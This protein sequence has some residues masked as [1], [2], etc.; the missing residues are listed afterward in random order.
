VQTLESRRL[1]AADSIGVT[2]D[3][4]GEYLVGTVLVTPVFFESNGE[5]DTETQNWTPDEI[6]EVLAKIS[7]GVNWWS[8]MLD[9]LD[10]VHTLEFTFDE[11]YA[12][13]PVS[14]PYEPIDNS[15]SDLNLSIGRFLTDAG[16]GDAST[17]ED[18]VKAF[19]HDQRIKPEYQ[20]DW[21]FTIFVADSSD[22]PDGLFASGGDF[23]A[24]FAYPGG[25]FMVSPSTRPASTFAH[26]MGHIFWA[27]D[28]YSNAGS[29]TDTRG[30]YNAQNLNAADNPT[31]GFVQQ[32]SIMRGGIP[33]GRAYDD[34]Q[35]PASTLA[36]VGWQDSDGDG[37]FDFA[38]VPLRLEGVGSFDPITSVYQFSGQ[39][40]VV[41]LRNLNSSGTQSDIALGQISRLEYRLDGAGWQTAAQIGA[42]RSN[43]QTSFQIE[44]EFDIIELRVI[45]DATGVTSPTITG[46]ANVAAV[47]QGG[48]IG[49]AFLDINGDGHRDADESLLAGNTVQVRHA[50]G[51]D[52]FASS[53]SAGE[54]DEGD[55][56]A[57]AA[58]GINLAASG[59][60]SQNGLAVYELSGQTK[61]VFQSFNLQSQRWTPRFD[62]K[63]SLVANLDS[64]VAAVTVTVGGLDSGSYARME[65][66]DAQGNFLTRQT[67][68]LIASGQETT[69]TVNDP[70]GK[71]RSV[72][73][74]G[75]ADTSITVSQLA[76]GT[77]GIAQ[78]DAL[79][80]WQIDDL[81]SGDYTIEI[82]PT[83]VI[84]DYTSL[85]SLVSVV[86][87]VSPM[88]MA[89]AA[90]VDSPRHNAETPADVNRLDGITALDALQIINDL[91][92]LG[93]RTLTANESE[94]FAI[95]VNNDGMATALDA[96]LVINRLAE[97]QNSGENETIAPLAVDTAF[98]T[99]PASSAATQASNLGFDDE[100]PP[101]FNL[102][103]HDIA[104][105]SIGSANAD[106]AR[107][108][109][110]AVSNELPEQ[111]LLR[112]SL[113]GH[114]LAAKNP[115]EFAEPF[116]NGLV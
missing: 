6:S 93:S 79:G 9:E 7:E 36:Q 110:I 92:R 47:A 111:P 31:E 39:A 35:S 54:F 10:T 71:I 73:V 85:P 77:S 59:L 5:V 44:T 105:E 48:I 116:G 75:H 57:S 108:A 34:L 68:A 18:A 21:S 16:Y 45:D 20:A 3:D 80:V 114:P 43:F 64:P 32:D 90:R 15:T 99:W 4:T 94:G 83:L 78:T 72:R 22:D 113:N 81:P 65:T 106:S 24:A 13:N 25:L 102:A 74:F 14:T 95:D 84:H 109:E 82:T 53:V 70:S 52:I 97:L 2:A 100:D 101:M 107:E 88:I 103:G 112:D 37:I 76:V 63:V 67:S 8:R 96:L 50:D 62:R 69:V 1:L 26:E 56:P 17:I 86:D 40:E 19:N 23:G 38:D 58:D 55:L 87:G 46:T 115:T 30:Y 66:Y 29:W 49:V 11:T 12:R 89:A 33:L 91:A 60:V 51:S 61:K 27:R 42:Q 98:Q 104:D 28:E 41:P